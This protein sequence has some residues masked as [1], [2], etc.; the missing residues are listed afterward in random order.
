MLPVSIKKMVVFP[1]FAPEFSEVTWELLLSSFALLAAEHKGEAGG[2]GAVLLHQ[3][4]KFPP[5]CTFRLSLAALE[6]V[7]K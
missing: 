6:H 4:H 5:P 2:L 1:L 7:K 3:T